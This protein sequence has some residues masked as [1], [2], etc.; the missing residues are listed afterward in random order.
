M[1]K[2]LGS[3]QY[4][5]ANLD[6]AH[7]RRLTAIAPRDLIAARVTAAGRL[8]LRL[9]LTKIIGELSENFSFY[10]FEM[11]ASKNS[12]CFLRADAARSEEGLEIVEKDGV[13]LHSDRDRY[14]RL[15]SRQS[16][17]RRARFC[18]GSAE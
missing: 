16:F 6:A 14:A 15:P 2:S 4:F 11:I 12:Q 7:D 1:I 8:T 9:S 18:P 13:Y 17:D 5:P 3:Q 10:A